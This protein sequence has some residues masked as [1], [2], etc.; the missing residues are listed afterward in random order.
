MKYTENGWSPKVKSCR[1]HAFQILFNKKITV[2]NET[3][4]GCKKLLTTL[5]LCIL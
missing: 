5:E 3:G 4:I 1:N 2:L